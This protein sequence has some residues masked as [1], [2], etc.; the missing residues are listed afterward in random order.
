MY[1]LFIKNQGYVQSNLSKLLQIRFRQVF[2][3]LR[4]Q[5]RQV[6]GL[7]RVQFRQVFGLLMV[8]FRQVSLYHDLNKPNPE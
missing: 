5:F 8:W 2:G 4:V 7:P 3:L 1:R 6:F